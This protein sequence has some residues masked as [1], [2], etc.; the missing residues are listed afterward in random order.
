MAKNE[1]IVR[2]GQWARQGTEPV[3]VTIVAEHRGSYDVRDQYGYLHEG[4]AK[5]AVK[6]LPD[7]D[8]A[9]TYTVKSD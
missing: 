3:I 2:R 5:R 1:T 9:A 8:E 4:V 6:L 7:T